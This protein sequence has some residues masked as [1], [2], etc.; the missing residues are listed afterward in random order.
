ME[1]TPAER[2]PGRRRV[3]EVA[4]PYDALGERD[5]IARVVAFLGNNL[6]AEILHVAKSQPGRWRDG[7]ERVSERNLRALL[8]LDYVIARL[9][10]LWE[11]EAARA[12]L[13]GDNPH[14]GGR[15][16]DVMRLRGS[17]AVV[18]ALDAD[19]TGAYA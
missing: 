3:R 19:E 8:D 17:I 15:P 5:R 2:R 1:I 14:A 13:D 10:M 4:V 12:W 6:T 16:I 9:L 7:T 11:P 18:A